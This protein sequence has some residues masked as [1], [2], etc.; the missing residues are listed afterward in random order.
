[1]NIC[2]LGTWSEVTLNVLG[3]LGLPK[4]KVF[5]ESRGR[6]GVI[7]EDICSQRH[8]GFICVTKGSQSCND[9]SL[10]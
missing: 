4:T 2:T 1:M 6:L 10:Y 9:W 5:T 8:L 3:F 7:T